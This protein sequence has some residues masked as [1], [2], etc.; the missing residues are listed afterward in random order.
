MRPIVISFFALELPP[1][2]PLLLPLSLPQATTPAA[3]A[4]AAASAVIRVERRPKRVPSLILNPS[5]LLPS[6]QR[7][8]RQTTF[9]ANGKLSL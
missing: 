8:R 1:P 4:A 6:V 2:P 7:P 5:P 3:S 9:S